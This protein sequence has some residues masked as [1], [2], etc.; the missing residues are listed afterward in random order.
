MTTVR[1]PDF[2]DLADAIFKAKTHIFAGCAVG[3]LLGFVAL[4]VLRPQYE[5]RMIVG[6]VQETQWIGS[7]AMTGAQMP[8]DPADKNPVGESNF[9]RFEQ[10]LREPSVAKNLWRDTA[11]LE[12][13]SHTGMF[14][15]QKQTFKSTAD[16]S[17][18]LRKEIVIEPLGVSQNRRVVVRHADPFVAE[19]LLKRL[20]VAADDIIRND[21]ELQTN[22]RISYL[23]KELYKSNN[24]EHR[25]V[26]AD[27]LMSQ[28]RTRMMV[29]MDQP[30]A[31]QVVEP[32][33]VTTRPV[34]PCKTILLPVFTVIGG[35]AG[36]LLWC[37]GRRRS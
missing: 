28:E 8:L 12:S 20:Q 5:A 35:L 24:P 23:Q 19:S 25:R 32:A 3:A 6:P 30:F 11:Y 7:I 16:L 37:L 26:L 36:F 15:G 1:D 33:S 2:I 34:S 13:L 18:F 22:D 4:G 29:A 17:R 10:I 27:L 21:A 31:A 14:R 9:I